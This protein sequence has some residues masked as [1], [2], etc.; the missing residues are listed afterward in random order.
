M[1]Y[2]IVPLVG[3]G[4]II[5]IIAAYVTRP[6][7]QTSATETRSGPSLACTDVSGKTVCVFYDSN[8][9]QTFTLPSSPAQPETGVVVPHENVAIKAP[10]TMKVGED[11]QVE[12]MLSQ[13][14]LKQLLTSA[15]GFPDVGTS[16][17]ASPQ[18]TV[19][20]EGKAFEI[21]SESPT[22]NLVGASGPS[23]WIF[24]V[25]ALRS[26]TQELSVVV[27]GAFKLQ[28]MDQREEVKRVVLSTLTR[29]V[30]VEEDW[31]STI[32]IFLEAYGVLLAISVSGVLLFFLAI[33]LEFRSKQVFTSR[34]V[35]AA[36][37]C[38]VVAVIA[39]F[40][41][42]KRA[43]DQAVENEEKA[44]EAE[45]PKQTGIDGVYLTAEIGL[46]RS[47]AERRQLIASEGWGLKIGP[48]AEPDWDGK[49]YL[50]WGVKSPSGGLWL[51]CTD[52]R[53]A[54]F[55]ND[56]VAF[57]AMKEFEPKGSMDCLIKDDRGPLDAVSLEY[58]Y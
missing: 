26:G 32:W 47:L 51:T 6:V 36:I 17:I 27:E 42:H 55:F 39:A 58:D 13:D 48:K 30:E 43:T 8:H 24:S 54:V 37:Y 7:P 18:V 2:V 21:V 56:R 28:S 9:P 10:E 57:N 50:H 34:V 23:K 12:V 40:I 11:G 45:Y 31:W 35:I 15:G 44:L 4:G 25:R 46:K 1:R 14:S 16:K 33:T 22:K 19:K 49:L 38:C 3:S 20:L 5:A 29:S 41:V 53:G 52:E